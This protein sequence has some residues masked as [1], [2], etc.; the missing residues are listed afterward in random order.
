MSLQA[1]TLG[2]KVP[3]VGH[4]HPGPW[5]PFLMSHFPELCLWLH[6]QDKGI[7]E[8]APVHSNVH[9]TGDKRNPSGFSGP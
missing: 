3:K 9:F 8:A 4:P 1:T 6:D 7:K 2:K 5:S